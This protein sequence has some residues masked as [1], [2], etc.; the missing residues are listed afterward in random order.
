[1]IAPN[2]TPTHGIDMNKADCDVDS[3][4]NGVSVDAIELS[5]AQA[6][7]DPYATVRVQPSTNNRIRIVSIVTTFL[8]K[9]SKTIV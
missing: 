7:L 1:M 8:F 2:I 4:P 6:Q 3:K 9:Q 5:T